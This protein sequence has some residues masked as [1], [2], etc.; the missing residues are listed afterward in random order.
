[1]FIEGY[2]LFK[3]YFHTHTRDSPLHPCYYNKKIY[4]EINPA[5]SHKKMC[6][7]T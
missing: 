3:I 2:N 7:Q 6:E 4:I 1:M 5:L